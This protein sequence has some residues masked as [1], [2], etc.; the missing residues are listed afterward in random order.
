MLKSFVLGKHTFTQSKPTDHSIK[1]RLLDDDRS[2][3]FGDV[4]RLWQT[5]AAYRS[6][7]TLTLQ[8]VP[9]T[10]FLWESPPLSKGSLEQPFESV[11]VDCPSLVGVTPD[12][13]T[14]ASYFQNDAGDGI[15]SFPN[16]GHDARLLAPCPLGPASAYT[17]LAAFVRQAPQQQ[18]HAL[19][20]TLGQELQACLGEHPT[21]VSTNGLGVFWLHLRLDSQPKY[22]HH[23]PYR[24]GSEKDNQ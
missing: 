13:Q 22:Y 5:S 11:L 23:A 21:W 9:F 1:I 14:F 16:L 10:A 4:L 2:V 15:V 19:W 7:F 18:V 17:H 6:L 12:R 20:R 24:I 8:S 3:S